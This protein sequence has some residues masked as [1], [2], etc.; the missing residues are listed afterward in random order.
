[1]KIVAS[2]LLVL[3]LSSMIAEHL[4]NERRIIDSISISFECEFSTL[5]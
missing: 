3:F 4:T 2:E 5:T 1:M